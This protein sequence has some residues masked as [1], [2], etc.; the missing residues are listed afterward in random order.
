M[1]DV[2]DGASEPTFSDLLEVVS[3]ILAALWIVLKIGA[4]MAV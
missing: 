3:L 4:S 2:T 1:F